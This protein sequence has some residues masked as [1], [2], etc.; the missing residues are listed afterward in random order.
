MVEPPDEY[1]PFAFKNPG[2]GLVALGA[3]VFVAALAVG[4]NDN[5]PGVALLFGAIICWTLAVVRR[6]QSPKAFLWLAG[7]AA[8]GFLVCAVL[9]NVLYG[10]GKMASGQPWLQGICETLHVVFFLLAVLVAPPVL[11]VGLIGW[12][13]A[14]WRQRQS[15]N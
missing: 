2:F 4:I 7:G 15:Q 1:S 8:V 14:G 6:W 9:H 13:V 10:L 3:L 5:L 12:L 11:F